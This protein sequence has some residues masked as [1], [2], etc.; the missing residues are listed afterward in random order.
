[1]EL[2]IEQILTQ[3]SE[4]RHLRPGAHRSYGTAGVGYQRNLDIQVQG[5][6][7]HHILA[8]ESVAGFAAPALVDVAAQFAGP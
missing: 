6:Y 2:A 7:D 3:W 5:E 4:A 1:M 8:T